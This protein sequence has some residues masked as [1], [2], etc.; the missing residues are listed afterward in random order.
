MIC[1][2]DRIEANA[3]AQKHAAVASCCAA[4]PRPAARW[5]RGAGSRSSGGVRRREIGA[6]LAVSALSLTGRKAEEA[7]ALAAGLETSLPGTRAAYHLGVVTPRQARIIAA[8][9]MLLDP[10]EARAAEAMVL[11]RAGSMT[12]AG[13]RAAI[14]RAVMEV[15]PRRR[16]NAGSTRPGT[17]M[18]RG[19]PSRREM[20]G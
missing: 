16:R 11:D 9:T 8:A 13:L 1:G 14:S 17:R 10:A 5:M 6:A 4:V 2:W 20:R 7:I 19:G 3:S 15:N 18:W 12:P